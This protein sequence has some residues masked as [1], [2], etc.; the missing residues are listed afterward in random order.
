MSDSNIL[1][2]IFGNNVPTQQ[3]DQGGDTAV[4]ERPATPPAIE[5]VK[6]EETAQPPMYAVLHNDDSTN[7]NFVVE[8][9]REVFQMQGSRAQQIMMAAHN[10]GQATVAIYS[11]E[12]AEA[13][14][15]QAT[16]KIARDGQGQ[17]GRNREAPC[18]LRFS[19]EQE[20]KGG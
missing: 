11:K 18:Q 12:I 9:L 3:P 5:A 15:E 14:L 19:I 20:T 16:L 7:F 6:K 8:V 1:K 10:N 17:N 13:K 4:I 2:R